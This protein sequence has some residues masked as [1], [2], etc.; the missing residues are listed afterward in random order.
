MT[1]DREQRLYTELAG[2]HEEL[3]A[4]RKDFE[5]R[6]MREELDSRINNLEIE[7][8][9]RQIQDEISEENKPRK[10]GWFSRG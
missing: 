5:G 6:G 3:H 8:R 1:E 9:L 7:E 2:I 4:L 10:R